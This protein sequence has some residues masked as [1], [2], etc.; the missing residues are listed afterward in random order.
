MQDSTDSADSRG[1]DQAAPLAEAA[2][3]SPPFSV[4]SYKIPSGFPEDFWKAGL[5]L[6]VPL[7]RGLRLA[8]LLRVAGA[9]RS[10]PDKP[11]FVLKEIVWPL[12]HQPLLSEN[13]LDFARQFALRQ[14]QP[15]GRVLYG[16]LPAGLRM[17]KQGL[18]VR[19]FCLSGQAELTAADFDLR[20]LG[21]LGEEKR[22]E[23]AR[24]WGQGLG[25]LFKAKD[26]ADDELYLL[27]AAPPWPVRPNAVK[28]LRLL[29]LFASPGGGSQ[30]TRRQIERRLGREQAPVLKQLVRKGLLE[31]RA[32]VAEKPRV[33]GGGSDWLTQ[34]GPVLSGALSFSLNEEQ[35]G[36]LSDLTQ[37]L[38]AGKFASRLLYGVTGSGKT[39]V[40]LEFCARVLLGGRS[41]LLLAP[42][43]GLALKLRRDIARRFPGLPLYL[44]H[45]YQPQAAREN[46]FR[47]L[48][49]SRK[50]SLVVGTRSALFL[51]M[52]NL[53]AIILDEEH[54]S[55]F[56][57]EDRFYYQ[58]KDLAWYK[59]VKADAVLVLGSATP[60]VK[61]FYAVEQGRI[62]MLRLNNR[63]CGGA[64]PEIVLA[65]MLGGKNGGISGLLTEVSKEALQSSL[66]RGEQAVILLNRRGYSPA[67]YCLDCGTSARCPNC[68]ITLT[69]HKK[70]QKLLCHYCGYAAPFPSPC[71]VC[72]SVHFLPLGE[73]T[74]KL[75]EVL[76]GLLP[77]GSRVLRLDRDST[78]RAG[79]ME[80]I[81][82]AFERGEADVLVGTQML[83]KGH[84][85]PRVTLAVVADGDLGLSMP[86]YNAA[87]RTFQLLLQTSGRAGRGGRPGKVIIQTRDIRHYCW[88]Y[89]KNSDYEGFYQYELALRR[90][91][92]YP[93]FVHLALAR[94]D[95]AQ[96]FAEG[97]KLLAELSRKLLNLGRALGVAVLGPAP[98]PIRMKDRNLRFQCLLKGLDWQAIRGVY[99]GMLK[100]FSGSAQ[101]RISLDIDPSNML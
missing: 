70:R 20:Q 87:E 95:F 38:R 1:Q 69:Y 12:E 37:V 68:E 42:E 60:D 36:A 76:P 14:A 6:A 74:E 49:L 59:A 82:Q 66:S 97:P 80:S 8:V 98:A 88:E 65:P 19:F 27:K 91:H 23:L 54:D 10:L 32:A 92:N 78:G 29:D 100:G 90:R 47:E 30:M 99:Y 64:L 11:A 25:K 46:C 16:M 62:R 73:G 51:Q 41:V 18:R 45:G 3:L 43:V 94:F 96:S 56:K 9:A 61:T 53:G 44:F 79:S 24:L 101:M 4:L 34:Y 58:A 35:T 5:R 39:A 50:P 31:L 84:H 75:E 83:S 81:L 13:Y 52:N 48:A 26:S 55:S 93:P 57:Q 77:A 85:F 7:G 33:S 89:V 63:V 2:L 40:Y 22:A 28:Q 15:E 86:D 71:P 17:L 21:A 72:K 67:M